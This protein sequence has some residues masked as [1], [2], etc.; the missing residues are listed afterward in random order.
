MSC[1]KL[2]TTNISFH[3]VSHFYFYFYF[4]FSSWQNLLL[5]CDVIIL[6]L[7]LPFLY[8]LHRYF[9]RICQFHCK[10]FLI[11]FYFYVCRFQKVN[12]QLTFLVLY[13]I[14]V[15]LSLA[16]KCA[17]ICRD[18]LLSHLFKNHA[19]LYTIHFLLSLPMK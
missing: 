9:T 12:L 4:L 6:L 13:F 16:N 17:L 15:F 19:K 1:Q 8:F 18:F 7:L 10:K 14:Q 3:N 11:F 2:N 5:S